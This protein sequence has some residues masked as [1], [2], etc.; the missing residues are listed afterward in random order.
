MSKKKCFSEKHNCRCNVW[1]CVGWS[2][3]GVIGFAV[4]VFLLGW[5]TMALWNWLIPGIF[6]FP[7]IS[8]IQA[9]GLII[10]TR[11]LFGSWGGHGHM[12]RMH[13][14]HYGHHGHQHGCCCA[15]EKECCSDKT[16]EEECRKNADTTKE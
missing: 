1:K 15:S 16:N 12:R 7:A 9:L 13:H 3:L 5:V 8:F 2:I 14:K 10:L 4:I 11:L 6:N